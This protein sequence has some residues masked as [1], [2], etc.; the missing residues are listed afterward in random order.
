[1]SAQDFANHRSRDTKL[2]AIALLALVALILSGLAI[3]GVGGAYPGQLA[4]LVLIVAFTMALLRMRAYGLI[5]QDRIIRLEM[6]VRLARLGIADRFPKLTLR[7]LIGLRF[8][9]DGELPGL[10]DKV[11]AENIAAPTDIKKLVREW[12]PDTQRI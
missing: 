10:I 11:L 6:E 8:A 9:S 7:Q 5:L 4:Q 12:R 3:A 1:M 2:I